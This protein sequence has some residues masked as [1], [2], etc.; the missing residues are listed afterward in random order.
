MSVLIM[1]SLALWFAFYINQDY[2]E[3]CAEYI[4][5]EMKKK[6]FERLDKYMEWNK[7]YEN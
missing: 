5:T 3:R 1:F 6:Y 2:D 7:K 4:L